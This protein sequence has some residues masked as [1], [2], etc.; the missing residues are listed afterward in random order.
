M[1]ELPEVETARRYLSETV[2]EK[3]IKNVE[4][5]DD[6]I[7]GGISAGELKNRLSGQMFR[8]VGRHGKWLFLQLK[9]DL[10]LALHL[11]MTG[12]PVFLSSGQDLPSHTRLMISFE[13]GSGL[14]YSDQRMFGEVTITSSSGSFL[15]ERGIGPDA[16]D[17][18]RSGFL[19]AMHR[20]RS[21]IKS[22]LLDQGLV[23]GIGNL[24]AD[25]ALF[26]AGILP[27]SRNLD[28]QR[29]MVLF[30]ILQEV[31]RTAISNQADFQRLPEGYLLPNRHP[32]GVCPRDGSPLQR[33]RIAGR[34]TYYCPQHQI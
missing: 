2:L 6:R 7:L 18:D 8:C 23:A 27:D 33:T 11:G 24:Y 34:T 3:I 32:G 30:S 1:P 10:W 15:E 9:E 14:A 17:L 4:V 20:R 26:Q 21:T 28:D 22:R 13:E 12:N 31:L 29:L 16:L 25:E 19:S 5:K